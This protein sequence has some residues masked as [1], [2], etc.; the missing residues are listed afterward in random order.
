LFFSS[1]SAA[2]DFQANDRR[3]SG[4]DGK[5]RIPLAKS[6]YECC[7]IAIP[8]PSMQIA[9]KLH[10]AFDQMETIRGNSLNMSGK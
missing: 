4:Q 9:F 1:W 5:P 8:R 7:K 2:A 10:N 6:G 3:F